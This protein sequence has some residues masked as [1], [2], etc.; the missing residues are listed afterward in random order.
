M[1]DYL[2]QPWSDFEAN[3]SKSASLKDLQRLSAG[4]EYRDPKS[5]FNGTFWEQIILRCGLS[6]EQT[7]FVINNNEID[8]FSIH[9][10][11]GMPVGVG[12]FLDVSFEYGIRGETGIN[13]FKENFL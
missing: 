4:L 12:N 5:V 3:N 10:G 9:A 7:Q 8:Q 2:Y 6:F 13:L 11:V 1:A